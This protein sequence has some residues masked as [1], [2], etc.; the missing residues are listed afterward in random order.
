[1]R[2]KL[3]LVLA[4]PLAVITLAACSIVDTA[5]DQVALRYNG[6]IGSS[7]SFTSCV[8]SSTNQWNSPGDS[9]KYYPKGQRSYSFSMDPKSDFGPLTAS[10]SDSQEITVQGIIGLTLNTTCAPIT[11]PSPDGGKTPGKTWPGGLLQK[12]HE[13]LANNE[14]AAPS[15]SGQPMNPGWSTLLNKYVKQALENAVKTETN[16]YGWE[17]LYNNTNN[18]QQAWSDA[19]IKQV[20]PNIKTI[21]GDNYFQLNGI[22]LQRPDIPEGLKG[23]L[24]DKQ[25]AVINSQAVEIAKQA[26]NSFPGGIVAYQQYLSQQAINKAIQD[27]KV[28]VI[29]IP[30]GSGV[31][32]QIPAPK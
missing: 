21:M 11:D 6:G 29:P 15:D 8:D 13:V 7:Q 18:V 2:R 31:N 22:I 27:G 19:V 10:S 32:V 14:G 5:P 26:A 3:A 28:Q 1:M 20:A 25:A 23:P 17:A 24:T 9:Y 16:K 12:F 30:Q 4:I